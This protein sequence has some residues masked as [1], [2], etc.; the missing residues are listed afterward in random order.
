MAKD[1]DDDKIDYMIA[2]LM[3][4]YKGSL[5]YDRLM[6]LPI[7][8]LRSLCEYAVKINKEQERAAK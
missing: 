5:S 3:V 7:P 6:S 4:F 2:T 1:D 8:K